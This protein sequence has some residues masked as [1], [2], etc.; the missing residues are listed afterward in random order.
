MRLAF[1]IAIGLAVLPGSAPVF[2]DCRSENAACVGGAK[3][4]FDSVAC[5]SLYRTCAAN[6]AIAAQKQATQNRDSG[7][8]NHM[9]PAVGNRPGRR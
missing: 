1:V 4:P 8:A 2:A 9:Q 6:Q 5:G 3:S 7:A